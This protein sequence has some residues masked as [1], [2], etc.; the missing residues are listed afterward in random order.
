MWPDKVQRNRDFTEY[1]K[2]MTKNLRL[3]KSPDSLDRKDAEK[4]LELSKPQK[5]S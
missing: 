4:T 1:T 3:T 5:S 2:S